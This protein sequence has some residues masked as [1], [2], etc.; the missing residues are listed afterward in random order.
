MDSSYLTNP[1]IFIIQ[2]IFGLY[3]LAIMLRFMLQWLRA[4]FYN[5]LAQALVK[6]TNPTLK[7]MRRVIP[8]FGGIDFPAIVLM[9]IL[10]MLTLFIIVTL[11]GQNAGIGQLFFQSIA[12]LLSLFLNVF[13]FA[14]L[15]QII[16]SWI[17]PGSHNPIMSLIQ[18]IT[19]PVMGPARRVIPAIGGLDLS[20]L[21]VILVIQLLKMLIILPIEHLARVV[22]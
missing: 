2:T 4:D 21:V 1:V 9:L 14:I 8:G 5:P 6:I 17:N 22:G 20:P 18:T 16:V 12:E 19:E 11:S 13:L 3:V 10:Q 15:I 7:P